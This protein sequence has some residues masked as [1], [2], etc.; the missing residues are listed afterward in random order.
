MSSFL[1]TG[2]AGF[3]GSSIARA[4]LARGEKVRGV[5][6]F[7][8]GKRE[9]LEHLS[10]LDFIEGDITDPE[11]CRRACREIDYVFHE[12]AIPSVP[13]SVADPVS[14]NEANVTGTLQVLVAARDAKVKRLVYAGSS[15]AYGNTEV[16]PKHE[17]MK[18]APISPYAVSK[19]TG[20]LYLSSFYQ[21]YGLE[22]VTIRY[23]NVFGPHQDPTSQ[24][25]G[26]LARF[27]TSMLNGEQPTIFGDGEQSRDFTFID[28]VVHGNLLAAAAPAAKVAGRVFNVATG[29]C[30]SLNETYKLLQRMTGY[31]NPPK[32]GPVRNG[33]V[34]DSLADIRAAKEALGYEPLVDFATGL[35]RTVDWYQT[36]SKALNA[37][38]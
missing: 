35:Q 29:S 14:C 5:D 15:S 3:I 27:T 23:F 8:T 30:I 10:A 22:T 9:N 24:Y 37:K 16:S 34:K 6:N 26:V 38:V 7:S 33:D 1:V 12:A 2:V 28:N 4:L 31:P 36:T 11:V 25:S 20:E 13:R 32:Y 21:V 17:G 19:L 18:P